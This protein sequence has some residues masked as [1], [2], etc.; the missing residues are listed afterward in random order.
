[1][2]RRKENLRE[3]L[4]DFYLERHWHLDSGLENYLVRQM[5]IR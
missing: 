3:I 2:E 5:V 4:M 1:M